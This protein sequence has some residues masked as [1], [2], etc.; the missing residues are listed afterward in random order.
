MIN[1]DSVVLSSIVHRQ[2]LQSLILFFSCSLSCP[3][4]CGLPGYLPPPIRPTQ[5]AQRLLQQSKFERLTDEGEVQEIE[6]EVDDD[7]PD[8]GA[9]TEEKEE[10]R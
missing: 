6:M 8:Q 7:Q 4:G 1:T 10:V 3:H 5:L 9:A 2:P